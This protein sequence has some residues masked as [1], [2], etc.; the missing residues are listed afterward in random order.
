MLAKLR[1]TMRNGTTTFKR[2]T[3]MQISFQEPDSNKSRGRF[4]L[5]LPG[6]RAVESENSIEYFNKSR[7]ELL[8]NAKLT[9]D[10]GRAKGVR[11]GTAA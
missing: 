9:D 8:P 7:C 2:G 3:I 11:L 10:E 1:W 6:T 5:T 4:R